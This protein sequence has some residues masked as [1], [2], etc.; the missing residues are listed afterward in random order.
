MKILFNLLLALLL[1]GTPSAWA[2]KGTLLYIP[3]D[4]RPVCMAYTVQS[5]EAAGWDV[6]TPPAEYI[7]SSEHG[8]NPDGLF[9]WLEEHA[10]ESVAIVASSDAL[11]YGGLID[12]R[13]HAL[14][15]GLLQQRAERL[16]SLKGN[17]GGQKVYIFSTIMR[18]P[19]ASAAP[20][21]PAYY[22][23]W[24]PSLFRLGALEDKLELKQLRRRE[25]RELADLRNAIPRDVL[26]DMYARRR[27]N[28]RT[29]E[30]LL[31]GVESGDFDY[32]LIGRDDTAEFSQ[33]HREAR[34]MDIL[35][36]ELPKERIRFFSGA[37]QLGMLLLTRASN[38]LQYELPLVNVSFAA[39]KG[40]E[41]IPF[42]EDD[43]VSWSARQHIYAAGAFPV[44]KRR[45]ADLVLAVNTPFD[46]VTLEAGNSQ[47]N[48]VLDRHTENFVKKLDRIVANGHDVALAD[49]KYGN[50]A[51]NALVREIFRRGLGYKLA[52]YGGWNTAGN[53]LGFA[54]SQGL[55]Q[56]MY[57]PQ[58]KEMLLQVR[59]LDDWAY[60][61]NVRG[62][63]Y[64][65]LIWPNY[66]PNSGYDQEQ[67]TAAED[68][69]TREIMA[70]SEPVMEGSV[71]DYRF[72]L[73]WNRMFEVYVEP[74]QDEDSKDG[75]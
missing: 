73:P 9:R 2:A 3:L 59:Y 36:S 31:H 14:P 61:A 21:E 65:E 41:T 32:L 20:V 42:Y 54:L 55:L 51:D 62:K 1:L 58:D 28:I 49:V 4:N 50:G 35:V 46:G 5:L 69:I 19:K 71:S 7:A 13:T 75:I 22:E 25:V 72:T 40:G 27:K 8:G 18:S 6:K 66:W 30:L 53:T 16:I 43:K 56:K 10:R 29:T 47:N 74:V 17:Y 70:V 33:A 12:S 60:Q 44:S 11:I 45:N 39:G 48:G 37:D 26:E 57:S 15:F 38:R 24:G 67:R 68:A 52:A 23:E 34:S 64:R 63:V